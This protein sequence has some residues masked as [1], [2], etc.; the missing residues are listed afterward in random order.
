MQSHVGG[1][2]KPLYRFALHEQLPADYEVT[3]WYLANHPESRFVRNL[4]VARPAADRRY[5]LL[6]RD[7]AIHHLDGR[8]ERR[9]IE[10]VRELRD[11]LEEVFLIALPDSPELEAALERV[12]QGPPA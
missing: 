2:W 10:S 6:N 7:F 5:A 11:L 12:V 9:T 4:V 1:Q 3:N 8:S